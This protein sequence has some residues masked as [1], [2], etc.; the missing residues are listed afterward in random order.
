VRI[1][2]NI[3]LREDPCSILVFKITN[4]FSD[5]QIYYATSIMLEI[6]TSI[7]KKYKKYL[8]KMVDILSIL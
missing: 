6:H 1:R 7:R 2:K 8:N 5:K 4:S 3:F